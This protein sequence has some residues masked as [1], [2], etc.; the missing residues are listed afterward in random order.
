MKFKGVIFDL[1]GVICFTDELHF[2]AWKQLADKLGIPF[3]KKI[4][5]RL[6]GVSRME[7]LEIVLEKSDKSYSENEKKAFADEKNAIYVESLKSM[8]EKDVS[9]ECLDTLKKL[10]EKKVK[11]AIG[12]SSKNAPLILKQIGLYDWFDAI[13]DGNNIAK[14]KPDPEVF[15]KASDMLGLSPSECLVVEDATAGIDA[16][17]NGG[18]KTAGLGDATT[19]SKTD[20]RLNAISDLLNIID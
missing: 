6:R 8:S 15:V 10:K 16:G 17:A 19:Y 13:S 20:Y 9:Q 14:S 7:S 5:N 4:N 3:D 11:I 1:D 12:S 2:S 18:F